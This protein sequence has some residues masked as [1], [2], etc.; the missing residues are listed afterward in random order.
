ML[1]K[2]NS[3][4]L[5]E[6][7]TTIVKQY[8]V[9][10]SRKDVV[11]PEDVFVDFDARYIPS[12]LNKGRLSE[13]DFVVFERFTNPHDLILDIGANCG[14][15]VADIWCSGARTHVISYE[16]NPVFRGALE[17]VRLLNP[18]RY[19]Y[20]MYGLADVKSSLKFVAP[21]IAGIPDTGLTT[22]N[23]PI[24]TH[25]WIARHIMNQVLGRQTPE[26]EVQFVELIA[27]VNRLDDVLVTD[28]KVVA[29]KLD[30]EDFEFQ[31][32]R[33]S[34]ETLKKHKPLVMLE[35]GNRIVGLQDWMKTLGY[36]YA[37]RVGHELKQY[38]GLSTQTNGY[39]IHP[40]TWR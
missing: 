31:V 38:S 11:A 16:P 28:R 27:D 8:Y 3:P 40:D 1:V 15:S 26:V 29:M 37:E 4:T 17:T 9:E 21:V 20:N 35:Q 5:L 7:I 36:E 12:I 32:L 6:D 2:R 25:Y 10:G 13:E 39:F 14:C 19:Q 34:V 18:D 23:D 22:A 24:H 30:V 33:G